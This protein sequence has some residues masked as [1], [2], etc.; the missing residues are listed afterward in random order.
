MHV[1]GCMRLKDPM[2]CASEGFRYRWELWRRMRAAGR[3][4]RYLQEKDVFE[5]YYKQH[6]AKRLLSGRAVRRL[7]PFTAVLP[8]GAGMGR[9]CVELSACGEAA[10]APHSGWWIRERVSLHAGS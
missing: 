8:Q 9:Q 5:K 7:L 2:V 6:L 4:R 1:Y 10:M 3:M